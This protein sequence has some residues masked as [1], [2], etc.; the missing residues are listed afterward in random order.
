VGTA[1]PAKGKTK[2]KSTL[3]NVMSRTNTIL[4][5]ATAS[6]AMLLG[7]GS[8]M[9]QAFTVNF[10]EFGNGTIQAPGAAPA[11]LVSLGNVTDPVD[12]GNGLQP[13]GYSIVTS[14]PGLVPTDGDINLFEPQTAGQLSDLLRFTHGM[15]LVYS[16]LPEVGEFPVPPADVGLP[17]IRQ[18]N[19]INMQETG[20]E[21]G[22]NG[23]FGYAPGPG[24]PGEISAP[25]VYNFLSDPAVPEPTGLALIG[26]GA[27]IALLARRRR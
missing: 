17:T 22:P 2:L 8:A 6:M 7:A 14:I 1:R 19:L 5:A 21:A 26:L 25:I 10:D 16:D 24:Q 12:P 11:T 15:L 23:M 9:A 20:P 3:E 13:L 18:P 4:S 27:G